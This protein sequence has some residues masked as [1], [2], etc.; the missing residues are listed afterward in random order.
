MLRTKTQPGM[1]LYLSWAPVLCLAGLSRGDDLP[2]NQFETLS[3]D[4]IVYQIHSLAT[5]YPHLAQ[6]CAK[7]GGRGLSVIPTYKGIESRR[8]VF[9]VVVQEW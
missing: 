1:R 7:L 3:Y 8:C 9:S 5:N 2:D 6:V 4:T